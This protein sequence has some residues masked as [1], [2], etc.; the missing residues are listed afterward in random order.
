[1][2]TETGCKALIEITPAMIEAGVRELR[3][4]DTRFDSPE[5]EVEAIFLAMVAQ[6]RL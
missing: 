2:E 6:M 4:Y 3:K 1:M 5:E